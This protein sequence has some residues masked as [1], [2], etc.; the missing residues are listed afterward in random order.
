MESIFEQA[1][2][3]EADHEVN[4]IIRDTRDE[5]VYNEDI[6]GERKKDEEAIHAKIKK[7][8]KELKKCKNI[9][10]VKAKAVNQRIAE[11]RV[12]IRKKIEYCKLQLQMIDEERSGQQN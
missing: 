10:N 12:K 1:L 11:R 2:D 9:P 5:F 4:R 6:E 7:Y 3:D 8:T